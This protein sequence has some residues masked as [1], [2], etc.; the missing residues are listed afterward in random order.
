MDKIDL[1]FIVYCISQWVALGCMVLIL[2]IKY[3][4]L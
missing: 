2:L 3:F 4:K 1:L